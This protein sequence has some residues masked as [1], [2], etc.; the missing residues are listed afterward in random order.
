M[1][2]VPSGGGHWAGCSRLGGPQRLL[3]AGG[4]AAARCGGG[5]TGAGARAR[6]ARQRP[7]AAGHGAHGL[8]GGALKGVGGQGS[9]RKGET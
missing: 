5:G 3:E 2:P 4:A 6:K 9:Y 8:A 1:V 7:P